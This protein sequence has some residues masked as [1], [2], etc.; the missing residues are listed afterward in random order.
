MY[1]QDLPGVW[2]EV[3]LAISD[4]GRLV[5][6]KPGLVWPVF[7]YAFRLDTVGS[8]FQVRRRVDVSAGRSRR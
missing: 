3:R 5:C 8:G 7:R 1:V 6:S 2:R 4:R